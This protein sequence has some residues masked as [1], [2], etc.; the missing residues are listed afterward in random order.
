MKTR[1]IARWAFALLLVCGTSF[2][3]AQPGGE[4]G[5]GFGGGFG[6][7]FGGGQPPFG[8]PGF[9]R[10]Q[11]VRPDNEE[12]AKRMTEEMQRTLQL[13]DKQYKKVY[14]ANLKWLD[15]QSEARSEA[16]DEAPQMGRPTFPD[17]DN[18]PG[19]FGPGNRPEGFGRGQRPEGMPSGERPALSARPDRSK[20]STLRAQRPAAPVETEALTKAR[21]KWET[22]LKK[23]LSSEQYEQWQKQQAEAKRHPRPHA[24]H[25]RPGGP[26]RRDGAP[27][28]QRPE[29][30]LDQQAPATDEAPVAEQAEE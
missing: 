14:K 5:G 13:T 8:E 16:A 19:G 20:D 22:K 12:A 25:Q 30:A 3:M 6:E 24:K 15:A 29:G 9:A 18:G 17:G 28:T 1:K 2:A 27:K 7:G 21:T 11:A 26:E 4:F 23:T 10:R